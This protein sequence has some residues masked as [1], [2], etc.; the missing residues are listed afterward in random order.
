MPRRSRDSRRVAPPAN[1]RGR[2]ARRCWPK[3]PLT[4]ARPR[5]G[6]DSAA[7]GR[8][9]VTAAAWVAANRLAVATDVAILAARDHDDRVAFAG[10][11]H[12]AAG[13]R[14]DPRDAARPEHVTGS[15]TEV[16]LDLA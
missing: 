4:R 14:V 16:E 15:V 12:A 9:W 8:V 10:V 13:A 3:G 2:A 5:R 1:G 6:P 11:A 7:G